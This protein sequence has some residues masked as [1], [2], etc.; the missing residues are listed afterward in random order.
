MADRVIARARAQLG[1]PAKRWA[2]KVDNR[3]VRQARRL[4]HRLR[5][6]PPD[7]LALGDSTWIFTAPDD[8]DPRD[9]EKMI[10]ARLG[11]ATS[12]HATWGA[13]YYAAFFDALLGL[14]R[15][16]DARPLVVVPLCE[17]FN[18]VAWSNHPFYRYDRAIEVIDRV[19][20]DTPTRKVRASFPPLTAQEMQ[21]YDRIPISTWAGD[22][23]VGEHRRPLKDPAAHGLTE[24]ERI[25]LLYAFHHGE[26]VLPT[27]PAVEEMAQMARTLREL[28][29]PVVAYQT[30]VPVGGGEEHF[31]PAFRARIE[32]GFEVIEAAFRRG[33][34]EDIPIVPT[35]TGFPMD[36]FI[37]P[38][39]AT[40]H[41]NEAGRSRLADALTT[42][43]A[44]RL[45]RPT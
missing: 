26:E 27:T 15:L 17:R 3:E 42:A 40:E 32:R 35:G 24:R 38:S 19:G 43:I 44:E 45:P 14:L 37:D 33:Y 7:V 20:V 2:A 8:R 21:D 16:V 31:G 22:M 23:T 28:E 12:L 39:D 5:H 13:G 29:V 18:G 11:P 25:A 36:E 4:L 1:P 30:P 10:A 41:L 34:G 9:L 6:D